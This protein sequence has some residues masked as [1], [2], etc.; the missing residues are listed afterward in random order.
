VNPLASYE[1]HAL[2]RLIEER[3][4]DTHPP[5]DGLHA[6]PGGLTGVIDPRLR[7]H[8]P[9]APTASAVLVPIVDHQSGLTVLMTRRAANLRRH[10]GQ[11]SFPGGRVEPSDAGL[12]EAALRETEEEIGLGREHVTFVGYLE[13]H[14]VLTGFWIAPVVGFVQPGFNLQLDPR[15]VASTFEVP[16]DHILDLTNHQSRERMIGTTTVRVHDIPY[17][18][19]NIWGAT[20]GILLSL[21][22]LLLPESA[23]GAL[24]GAAAEN[25]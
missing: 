3:L 22:R 24:S 23:Q 17:G 16:L 11:I 1:R 18:E 9:P 7:D 2:R 8:F 13:P 25:S 19:D 15:E 21:Y 4:R 20:A 14:L 10:A 12:L 6:L 5:V